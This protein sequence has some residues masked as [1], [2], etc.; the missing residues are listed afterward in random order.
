MSDS[1]RSPI[2]SLLLAQQKKNTH[3][4]THQ[5]DLF[6]LLVS[7]CM[8]HYF[9]ISSIGTSKLVCFLEIRIE[10]DNNAYFHDYL[11]NRSLQHS[12]SGM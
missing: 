5:N 2:S 9:K 8:Y 3:T 12:V 10:N 11:K 7:F 4:H 6:S 1:V